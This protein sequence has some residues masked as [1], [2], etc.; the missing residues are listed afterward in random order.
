MAKRDPVAAAWTRIEKWLA[1]NAG[2]TLEALSRGASAAS[3]AEVER[4]TGVKLPAA[5]R[6]SY[7]RLDGDDGSGIFPA[8]ETE[9]MA[10]SPMPLSRV[11]SEWRS[12][13]KFARSYPADAE[14]DADR[15]IRRE[16]WNPG[17]IPIATNGGGDYHC[18]DLS[19]AAG[20]T[21]GQVI[22]WRHETDERRL[23]APSWEH[24]LTELADGLES[25]KYA[26]D[27]GHGVVRP[28]ARRKS[29]AKPSRAVQTRAA[30]GSTPK[31]ARPRKLSAHDRALLRAAREAGPAVKDPNRKAWE[32]YG[33]A[34]LVKALDPGLEHFGRCRESQVP[35]IRTIAAR[36]PIAVFYFNSAPRGGFVIHGV[37]LLSV[38]EMARATV[39][40]G[41][42]ELIVFAVMD[43]T[44]LR[45]AFDY[46]RFDNA[47]RTPIVRI[48]AGVKPPVP[49]NRDPSRKDKNLEKALGPDAAAHMA[50]FLRKL[51]S[52]K[53]R[54]GAGSR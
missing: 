35:A 20:G 27:E 24:R 36:E 49:R 19:P 52:P 39:E 2:E 33:Y 26:Y 42:E 46:S 3:I 4:T 15:G 45:F 9:E 28:R 34:E 7:R 51:A 12:G 22:E 41:V 18:I 5:V 25:G 54:L 30:A 21:V 50:D 1:A 29:K 14:F 11:A 37:R 17:W 40:L 47:I 48:P 38:E 44:N 53:H 31:P 6:A 32:E 23:L 16:Y 10:Y 43:D 8:I 13:S